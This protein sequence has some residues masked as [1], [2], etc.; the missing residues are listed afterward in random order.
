[1]ARRVSISTNGLLPKFPSLGNMWRGWVSGI[2]HIFKQGRKSSPPDSL[3]SLSV[4]HSTDYGLI[5]RLPPT[6]SL[7]QKQKR[8][9][10]KMAAILGTFNLLAIAWTL[11]WFDAK[12]A[13][14]VVSKPQGLFLLDQA[15]PYVGDT[16]QFAA[17]VRQVAAN[18]DVPPGWLMAVMYVE[19]RFQPSIRNRRGSGATG[20]IQIM[21]P[22]LRDL[23]RRLGTK[24]Y[25][26]DLRAMTASQQMVLV[27]TYLRMVQERYGS[28]RSLTDLYLAV[29]Y[30]K[31]L[32]R[33]PEAGCYT[34]FTH[35][36]RTYRSNRGLD[37]NRD[38]RITVCDLDQR[39][40]RL[41]PE[42]MRY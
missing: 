42:M 13:E 26:R 1:M 32:A 20:L 38:K 33:G 4:N 23:N 27:E 17:Q 3:P 19:S 29:L 30:P 8:S 31:A 21:A 18:I 5:R 7:S 25:M 41:F 14:V 34:L 11:G 15:A 39:F 10:L 9:F 12:P 16:A 36:S 2:G 35:P 6:Q 24:Y 22:T 28:F 37:E 40:A